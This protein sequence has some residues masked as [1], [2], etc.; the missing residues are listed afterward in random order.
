MRG[1]PQGQRRRGLVGALA[2]A[3][4]LLLIPAAVGLEGRGEIGSRPSLIQTAAG[5]TITMSVGAGGALA[6]SPDAVPTSGQSLISPGEAVTIDITNLGTIPHTFTLS[7]LVNYTLPYSGNTNLTGT[8][9][10]SHPPYYSINISG[11]QGSVTVASFTAPT[12]IGSYQ[13]FCT[14]PGH[15]AAGMEGFLGVGI[16]VGPPPPPPSIGTPVFII[17]GVVVGLVI[18]AIVLGFVV[19]KREGSKYEMPPERLGYPETPPET[20][21]SKPPQ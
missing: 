5:A 3:A 8:F 6:F 17:A 4:L 15:F 9:L 19:G 18:L 2:I 1:W 11:T 20:P 10:V 16:T 21:P 14:E 13:W 7:S 12:G